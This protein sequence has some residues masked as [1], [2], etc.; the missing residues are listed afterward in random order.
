MLSLYTQLQQTIARGLIQAPVNTTALKVSIDDLSILTKRQRIERLVPNRVQQHLIDHMTGRDLLLKARQFGVS[1]IIQGYLFCEALN[2]T[3]RIG[4]MA[5]D[6]EATQKL[7]DMQQL[8]YDQLPQALQPGRAVNNAT[9]AYYPHTK[10]M[11]YIGTA[12]NTTGGRAGTYSHFHGSE[13]AFWKHGDQLIAGVLQGVPSDGKVFLE[14]TANGA[15]GWFYNE[16]MAARR[17]DSVFTV[18]F[19]PWWWGED[20]QIPLT[21]HE[22]MEY[23]P[24]EAALAQKHNLTPE[25]IKWRRYKQRELKHLFA[26]EYPESIETAFLTSGSNVF[27]DFKHDAIAPDKPEAGHRYAAGLDWGQSDDYTALSIMDATINKE[28]VIWRDRRRSWADMRRDVLDL[29]AFWNVTRLEVELN[30]ASSNVEELNREANER[31]LNKLIIHAFAMSNKLKGELVSNMVNGFALD[32]LEVL[33]VPFATA[34]M[35]QW[36]T[37][38]TESGLWAYTHPDGGHDDTIIA[39][40]AAWFACVSYGELY[41]ETAPEALRYLFSR[42]A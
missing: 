31:G 11:V 41:M 18:H 33:D 38:Q 28:V 24:D 15:Q 40:L 19:Y 22:Q 8:F 34:E 1:T 6:D 10:S 30:S 4:V 25:Q 23:T 13:V 39:R 21:E 17:G 26:Q 2:K 7:R 42:R 27:G 9:R 14:S 5:H 36:Q 12:G 16:I 32:G 3:S 37:K 29:C 35:Q 20:Y